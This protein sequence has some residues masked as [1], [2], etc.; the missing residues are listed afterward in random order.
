MTRNS[1]THRRLLGTALVALVLALAGCGGGSSSSS[2]QSS[3]STPATT[4]SSSSSSPAT[5]SS[6]SSSSGG[7]PQGANA[8]DKDADNQGGPS[9][10]DGNL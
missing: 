5:T 9:D 6:S 3:S 4:T 1:S 2:S 8:G 10:G 7:I